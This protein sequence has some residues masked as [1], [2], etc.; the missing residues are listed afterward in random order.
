MNWQ[1]CLFSESEAAL[2]YGIG[3]KSAEGYYYEGIEASFAQYGLTSAV[4]EYKD[5]TVSNGTRT[6]K[7]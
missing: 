3:S 7:D 4:K 5:K 1:R 2:R 6:E